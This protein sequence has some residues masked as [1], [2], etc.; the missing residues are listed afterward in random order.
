MNRSALSSVEWSEN[1]PYYSSDSIKEC[2]QGTLCYTNY[3]FIHILNYCFIDT[4]FTSSIGLMYEIFK[5]DRLS[6]RFVINIMIP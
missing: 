6:Y 1:N 3:Y 4:E 2:N 5:M